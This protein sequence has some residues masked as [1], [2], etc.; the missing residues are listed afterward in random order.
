VLADPW[1]PILLALALG[2]ARTIPL[3]WLVPA[4]GGPRVAPEVRIGLGLLLAV[5][6]LPILLPAVA[7]SVIAST[8][9]GGAAGAA[10]AFARELGAVGWIILIARELVVGLSVGLAAG[11]VFRAAESAGRLVDVLR[12]ANLAEVLSPTSDERTSPTGDLYLFVA[13]VLFLEM[14]GLRLFAVA[15]AG[16]YQAVPIGGA[17]SIPSFGFAAELAVLTAARLLESAVAFAAPVVVA[18]W[19]ADAALGVVARAAPQI[20]LYFAAMPLKA[21][22]GLGVVLVGLGAL[23]ATLA[24]GLPAWGAMVERA[25]TVWRGR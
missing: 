9:A 23:E 21:L 5:L 24:A 13:V 14:G 17:W 25:F 18:L 1:T 8:G 2:A 3:T 12:G 10:G 20:P 19:V 22:L 15:L 16:S 7:P 4:L 6:C 11:T